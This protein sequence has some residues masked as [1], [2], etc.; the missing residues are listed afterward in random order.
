[1]NASQM[2]VYII[3]FE[4]TTINKK[5]YIQEFAYVKVDKP[6]IFQ[7]YFL[8]IPETE[9]NT[10]YC[11]K[12]VHFIPKEI[13]S[14]SFQKIMELLLKPNSIF[15][16]KGAFKKSYIF[17]LVHES[18]IVYDLE[19]FGCPKYDELTESNLELKCFY[20]GHYNQTKNCALNK[21]LKLHHWFKI[22]NNFIVDKNK[23]TKIDTI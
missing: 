2:N 7:N 20:I 16:T 9:Y 8:T 3:D 18:S 22:E 4:A 14:F 5:H 11:T 19:K 13:G 1:M 17:R 15:L 23:L 10:C 12:Y 6:E 21:V